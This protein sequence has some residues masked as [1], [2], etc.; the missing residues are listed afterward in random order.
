MLCETCDSAYTKK[1]WQDRIFWHVLQH[2]HMHFKKTTTTTKFLS[3]FWIFLKAKPRWIYA[4]SKNGYLTLNFSWK[5]QLIY[6]SRNNCTK[7]P[8]PQCHFSQ[9]LLSP[10]METLCKERLLSLFS[11]S[12]IHHSSNWTAFEPPETHGPRFCWLLFFFPK[13]L[14]CIF[15]LASHHL[16]DLVAFYLAV[17]F[18]PLIA[19]LTPAFQ[20]GLSSRP[21]RVAN[22]C[23]C[24][25][26]SR[27]NGKYGTIHP[28]A[29]IKLLSCRT[30]NFSPSVI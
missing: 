15:P 23:C 21:G 28:M 3:I 8:H 26:R 13:S 17:A 9:I 19:T 20:S 1:T 22:P 10:V 5:L 29:A 16:N 11:F 4:L 30:E 27:L 24:Y 12:V 2:S 14:Y 7:S 18:P 6:Q 25:H